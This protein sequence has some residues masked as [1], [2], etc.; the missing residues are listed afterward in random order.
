MVNSLIFQNSVVQLA[1]RDDLSYLVSQD[2]PQHMRR[3]LRNSKFHATNVFDEALCQKARSEY[4][5]LVNRG[6]GTSRNRKPN[7]NNNNSY[8]SNQYSGNNSYNSK[9]QN[10]SKFS[11]GG[12]SSYQGK[13]PFKSSFQSNGNQQPRRPGRGGSTPKKAFQ[14]RGGRY[15]GSDSNKKD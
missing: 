10:Q 14:G 5:D 6:L 11:R 3:H 9:N 2:V 12:G 1:R 8:N 15:N 7:R 4:L 13:K